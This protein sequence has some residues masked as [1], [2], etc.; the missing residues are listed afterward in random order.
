MIRYCTFV[1]VLLINDIPRSSSAAADDRFFQPT[2]IFLMPLFDAHWAGP[3]ACVVWRVGSL[4]LRGECCAGL[5]SLCAG[6]SR[7]ALRARLCSTVVCHY[8]A[9]AL[10]LS[11]L[12]GGLIIGSLLRAVVFDR[13]ICTAGWAGLAR[14]RR[15]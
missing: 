10:R 12:G 11:H 4:A 3:V 7:F 8:M 13:A 9:R 2:F 1:R 15:W 14:M 6:S 5:R